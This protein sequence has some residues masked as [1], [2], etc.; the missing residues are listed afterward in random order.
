MLSQAALQAAYTSASPE[1]NEITFCVL[2]EDYIEQDP[3]QMYYEDP[4]CLHLEVYS[5]SDW[6]SNKSHRK[7]VSKGALVVNTNIVIFV[8]QAQANTFR[9]MQI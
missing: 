1:L 3:K 5:D 4:D 7:S 8:V 2:R 6:A 9:S